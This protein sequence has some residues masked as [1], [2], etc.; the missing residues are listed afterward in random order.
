MKSHR[1]NKEKGSTPT[2][3]EIVLIVGDEK[4]C[5]EWKMEKVVRLI[6]GKDGVVRGVTLLHKG[7]TI[8][9]TTP[10]S[11]PPG[12]TFFATSQEERTN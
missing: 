7:H 9:R 12:E 2:V 1:L 11:L 4:N 8:E 3:G 6:E 10:A 5:G